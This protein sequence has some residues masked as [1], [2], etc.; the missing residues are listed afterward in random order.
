MEGQSEMGSQHTM[1]RRLTGQEKGRNGIQER[2]LT[3]MLIAVCIAFIWLR[4]P[5]AIIYYAD[6]V[7]TNTVDSIIRTLVQ[8]GCFQINY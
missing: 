8:N 7:P 3:A 4:L 1:G 5:Y 6:K 2:Q